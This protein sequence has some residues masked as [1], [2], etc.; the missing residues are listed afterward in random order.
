MYRISKRRSLC[1]H[2]SMAN[3]AYRLARIMAIISSVFGAGFV[4]NGISSGWRQKR[5]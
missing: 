2:R 5:M 3:A 1:Y 4:N